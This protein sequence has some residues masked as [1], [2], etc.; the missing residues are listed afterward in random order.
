MNL[1][2]S[3][4]VDCVTQPTLRCAEDSSTFQEVAAD[5]VSK[6]FDIPIFFSPS[7]VADAN[8][9]SPSPSK[10]LSAI[11]SWAGLGINLH[12]IPST[13]ATP[14]QFYLAHDKTFVD[15]ILNCT[16]RNGFGQISQE[17]SRSLPY[18]T[19]AMLSAARHAHTNGLVAVAPV[20]G[21][22]HAGWDHCGGYCTFNGLMVTAQ[23]LKTEGTIQRIGILDFDQHWGDGTDEIV[24]RL[25]L[26]SW[27]T[28]YSPC[29]EFGTE[30][31]AGMFVRRIPELMERFRDTDLILYQAVPIPT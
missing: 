11:Q 1:S 10:P 25:G 31:T 21:F 17:V 5:L 7:M 20:S 4:L 24:K 9:F 14:E 13:P 2:N 18:T 30:A 6:V 29:S 3:T 22:H 19:G 12:E 27:V 15:E 8:S 28:H 16:R 26:D 23:V